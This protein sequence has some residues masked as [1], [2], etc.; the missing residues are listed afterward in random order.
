MVENIFYCV[1]LFWWSLQHL[2]STYFTALGEFLHF[3]AYYKV[4]YIKIIIRSNEFMEHIRLLNVSIFSSFKFI[5]EQKNH[6]NK[7]NQ[8]HTLWQLITFYCDS[9]VLKKIIK[10]A[11]HLISMTTNP[12]LP[13]IPTLNQSHGFQLFYH[14]FQIESMCPHLNCTP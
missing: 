12:G 13:Y 2:K 4:F 11:F 5:F 10:D 14:Y 8:P 3:S 6:C 9:E 1:F 7:E